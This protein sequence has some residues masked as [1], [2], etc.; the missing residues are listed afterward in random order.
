MGDPVPGRATR[1]RP[2]ERSRKGPPI[3]GSRTLLLGRG[4]KRDSANVLVDAERVVH[5][6]ERARPAIQP[7]AEAARDAGRNHAG[8]IGKVHTVRVD[9][10]ARRIDVAAQLD[11]VEDLRG[12][13]SPPVLRI[14]RPIGEKVPPWGRPRNLSR[15]GVG[16]GKGAWT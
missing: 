4:V 13:K 15:M 6:G 2:G 5:R 10:L 9:E 14:A 1:R 16:S 7:L 8:R 12:G 3:S 11:G